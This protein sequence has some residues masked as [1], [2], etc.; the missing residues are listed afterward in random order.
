M[1]HFDGSLG[2]KLPEKAYGGSCLLYDPNATDPWHNLWVGRHSQS[3]LHTVKH[4]YNE[5]LGT[6]KFTWV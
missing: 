3:Y 5:V 1:T 6:S 2:V 4:V